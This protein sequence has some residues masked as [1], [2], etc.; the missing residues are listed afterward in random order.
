MPL[1]KLPILSRSTRRGP[2]SDAEAENAVFHLDTR[3]PRWH[4]RSMEWPF[5]EAEACGRI[6]SGLVDRVVGGVDSEEGE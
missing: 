4:G 2:L 6:F 5:C 3:A 1:R